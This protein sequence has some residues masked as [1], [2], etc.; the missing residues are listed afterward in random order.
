MIIYFVLKILHIGNI[1]Q[2]AITYHKQLLPLLNEWL[3]KINNN[4]FQNFKS[5]E[6]FKI[7][8]LKY[9]V[10]SDIFCNKNNYKKYKLIYFNNELL[11]LKYLTFSKNKQIK[12]KK[13]I[14]NLISLLTIDILALLNVF[15]HF[16]E[17][18]EGKNYKK[19]I[20]NNFD[21]KKYINDIY[22]NNHHFFLNNLYT[23]LNIINNYK[24]EK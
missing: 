15:K 3:Y 2:N 18:E 8:S 23:A 22:F 14:E 17:S 4:I 12:L 1:M 20:K 13:I 24:F 16:E 10:F 5:N 11:K 21:N 7:Y 19:L 6:L 9:P